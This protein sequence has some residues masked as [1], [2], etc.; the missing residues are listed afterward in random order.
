[1]QSLF[2][3]LNILYQGFSQIKHQGGLEFT[4]WLMHNPNQVS[5][6]EVA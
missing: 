5:T 2:I 1:M 3:S 6:I 4:V